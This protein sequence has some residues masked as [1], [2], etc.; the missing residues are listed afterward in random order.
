MY[1]ISLKEASP[2]QMPSSNISPTFLID[3][4][5]GYTLQD[6]DLSPTVQ[7]NIIVWALFKEI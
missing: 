4:K 3:L 6:L 2:K 5:V 1:H 7:G